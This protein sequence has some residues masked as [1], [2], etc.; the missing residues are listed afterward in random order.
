VV[1]PSS[2]RLAPL[3]HTARLLALALLLSRVDF[4]EAAPPAIA[5]AFSPTTIPA[6]GTSALTFTLTNPNASPLTG[7]GFTDALPFGMSVA[8]P[9]GLTNNTC[10]AGITATAGTALISLTSATLAAGGSCAFTVNVSSFT[11]GTLDN[12]TSAVT[13]TEGGTG[14]TAAASLTVLAPL[15]PTIAKAFA[16]A[17]V[18]LGGTTTLTFTITNPNPSA[19]LSAVTFTDTLPAGLVVATPTGITGQCGG[20]TLAWT[21]GSGTVSLPGG[22]LPA[23]SSCTLALNVTG[24]VAGVQNNTTSAVTSLAGTGNSA[25]ASLDVIA[26]PTL[27]K[28]FAAS[29][30]ALGGTTTLAFTLTNPNP[31]TALTGVGFADPLPPGL[32]VATP[33]GA[34]NTCG[35]TLTAVAGSANISLAGATVPASGSCVAIVNVTATTE[36]PKTNTTGPVFS[37]QAGF[38]PAASAAITVGAAPI[39]TLATWVFLLLAL[40]LAAV[41]V[42]AL[43]T[44]PSR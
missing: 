15:P 34:S 31:T 35:G 43:R 8:T 23:A 10:G 3:R 5:K 17:S 4:A 20:N 21:P 18:G 41:A 13:S 37:P 16:A 44:H 1:R 22:V 33:N 27:A 26:Q 42:H 12:Q 38:S 40:M 32:V 36:G 9:N 7:V 6:A 11:S 14:N 30:I 28:A 24:V 25:S 2:K 39:P 29:A 19:S